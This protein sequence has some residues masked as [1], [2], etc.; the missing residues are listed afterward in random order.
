MKIAAL[1]SGGVDSSVALCQLSR[2]KQYEIRAYYLKIWLEDELSFLGNCPWEEDLK[3]ARAVC[4]GLGVPLKVIPLQREYHDRIVT[5]TTAEL[6]AGRTPSPDIFCNKR[7]KFGAFLDAIT[8]PC[9][10]IAT[11]HYANIE[12]H[13]GLF[14]LK[15]AEDSFKD[16]TYFLSHLDQKQLSLCL[17]PLGGFPKSE[18]RKLAQHY[19]LPN[20]NRKDSQGIC[21]LGKIKYNDFV[22]AHLGEKRGLIKESESQKN[23]GEHRGYWFHTIGQR[24]GLGLSGGPWYVTAKDIKNNIIYVSSKWE[25]NRSLVTEFKVTNLNWISRAPKSHRLQVKL[26][27]QGRVN[28]CEIIADSTDSLTVKLA[29]ADGG[30]ASGQFAVF[31]DADICLGSGIIAG[32]H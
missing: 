12:E 29:I 6:K 2:Q 14:W 3:Y 19:R 9:D 11:G 23:L 17:F 22:R 26:R 24:K 15:N 27:H 25:H 4:E 8:D 30:V 21:F 1:I 31:Y 7:I 20:H 16:Q 32:E 10:K 13:D 5:Y 28:D 18:V